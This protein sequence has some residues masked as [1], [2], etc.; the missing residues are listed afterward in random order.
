MKFTILG[1]NGFIGKKLT[2]Y[3]KEK[4]Y[5]CFTP[6]MREM[7]LTG[8]DLGHVIYLIGVPNFMKRPFDAVDAHVCLVKKIL[9]ECNF[10]SFLYVSA[11]RVYFKSESTQEDAVIRFHPLEFNDLY[12]ISKAMG[13]SLCA[14][15]NR[16]NVRIARLSNVTGNN[17][18][19]DLFLPS[20]IRDAIQK[21]KITV[22]TKLSSEKDYIYI[23][24]VVKILTE[25]SLH[26]KNTL[27]NIA[28]GKNIKSKEIVEK[29]AN[30]VKCE[31][32]EVPNAKEYSFP[33]IAIDRIKNEFDFK[34]ISILDKI[35]EM[36]TSYENF[37]KQK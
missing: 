32:E 17:F 5:E 24:D 21:K 8:M 35:E 3:L 26:G 34:P 14:S 29:I 25:I 11:T 33:E 2:S 7:S 23:D 37:L 27:Y 12:G 1:A 13:E 4:G 9:S 20:I 10:D 31:I 19:S 36:V 28:F 6:E 15:T 16:S 30:I 22:H 18:T